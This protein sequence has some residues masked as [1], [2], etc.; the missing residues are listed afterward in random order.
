[1]STVLAILMIFIVEPCLRFIMRKGGF[2]E[3]HL[4]ASDDT[5]L[6]RKER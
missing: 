6:L 5:C 2:I 4:Q 3:P 1:V